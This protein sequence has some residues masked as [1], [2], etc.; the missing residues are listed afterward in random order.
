MIRKNPD[1]DLKLKYKKVLEL[2][3]VISLVLMV[4]YS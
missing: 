4:V 1:V 3:M 2:G